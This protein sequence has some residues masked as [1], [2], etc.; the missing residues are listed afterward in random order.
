MGGIELGVRGV[1][2]G[3]GRLGRFVK[4]GVGQG[5]RGWRL[6]RCALMY[7]RRRGAAAHV[8]RACSLFGWGGHGGSAS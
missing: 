7:Y 1:L 4:G 5:G 3:G 6:S 2:G 8:A